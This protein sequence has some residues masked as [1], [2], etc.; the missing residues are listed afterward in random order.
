M[1]NSWRIGLRSWSTRPHWDTPGTR[2]VYAYLSFHA[3]IFAY[4]KL[5]S[6]SVPGI[7]LKIDGLLTLCFPLDVP[8][9]VTNLYL[10]LPYLFIGLIGESSCIWYADAQ[11]FGPMFQNSGFKSSLPNSCPWTNSNLETQKNITI[12]LT[13]ISLHFFFTVVKI[14]DSP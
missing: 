14:R 8:N 3:L 1:Q 4:I 12:Q 11:K 5:K 7:W 6:M 13:C 2:T 10:P 9:Y